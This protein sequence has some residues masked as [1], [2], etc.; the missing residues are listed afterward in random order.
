MENSVKC[1]IFKVPVK[2]EHV[3]YKLFSVT[4]KFSKIKEKIMDWSLI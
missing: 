3:E 4:A 2:V 1:R